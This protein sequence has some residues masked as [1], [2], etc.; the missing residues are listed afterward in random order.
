GAAVDDG[1]NGGEARSSLDEA[2]Q[3]DDPHDALQIAVHGGLDLGDQVDG[4]QPGAGGGLF[5]GH[6]DT[7]GAL[8]PARGVVRQLARDVDQIAGLDEGD[9][10]GDRLG[11]FGQG[12]VEGCE[13][14][15]D[16]HAG[17]PECGRGLA[18]MPGRV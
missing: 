12:D 2:A 14:G 17:A 8:D 9:I 5:R 4:A 18:R 11:G 15:G 10:A 1:G 7:D 3:F 16:G 13:A 6:V